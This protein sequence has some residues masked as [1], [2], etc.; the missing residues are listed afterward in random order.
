MKYIIG[1]VSLVA[2]VVLLH[3]GAPQT[4]GHP[5]E[6][7][8]IFYNDNIDHIGAGP[9][10]ALSDHRVLAKEDPAGIFVKSRRGWPSLM[11]PAASMELTHID[12]SPKYGG[13]VGEYGFGEIGRRT[14]R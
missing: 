3:M 7:S 9:V 6:G 12:T 14:T 4:V 2:A 11:K 5:V 13:A 8:F 10:F 1:L